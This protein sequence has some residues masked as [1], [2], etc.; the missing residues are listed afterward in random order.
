MISIKLRFW[1]GTVQ[2]VAHLCLQGSQLEQ[3]LQVDSLSN[4]LW[5]R[6]T[7]DAE[8]MQGRGWEKNRQKRLHLHLI[9]RMTRSWL[10]T[11]IKVAKGTAWLLLLEGCGERLQIACS[12]T[13]GP[14][15]LGTSAGVK[16]W[17]TTRKA[18]A[19]FRKKCA[20]V[21]FYQWKKRLSC[22]IASLS[23]CFSS[24]GT[25]WCL[26]DCSGTPQ[27]YWHIIVRFENLP[28]DQFMEAT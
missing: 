2:S 16:E 10:I 12:T 22:F 18:W 9:W 21:S 1:A 19:E 23:D 15:K 3:D 6:N 14:I 24:W 17:G 8:G 20:F 28:V 13:Y 25:S 7:E 26:S 4:V 27:F 11:E 5:G